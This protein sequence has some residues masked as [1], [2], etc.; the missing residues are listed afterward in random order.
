MSGWQLQQELRFSPSESY[1][2]IW[3]AAPRCSLVSSM[4]LCVSN[5]QAFGNRVN[6]TQENKTSVSY[7]AL[8]YA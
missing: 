4:G 5:G 3:V 2:E 7:I 6:Q 1:S 8:N